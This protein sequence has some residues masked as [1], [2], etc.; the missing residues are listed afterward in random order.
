M[1]VRKLTNRGNSLNEGSVAVGHESSNATSLE[2]FAK[3]LGIHP[4]VAVEVMRIAGDNGPNVFGGDSRLRELSLSH[5]EIV[6][7]L[8]VAVNENPKVD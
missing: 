2:L 8:R 3:S 5:K 4:T 6:E 7:K 1:P